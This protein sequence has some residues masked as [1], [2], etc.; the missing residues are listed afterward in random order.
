MHVAVDL[1]LHKD[2]LG[3]PRPPS[4][5]RLAPIIDGT[6]RIGRWLRT[7]RL[8]GSAGPSS[9]RVIVFADIERLEWDERR[10][11]ADL[12]SRLDASPAVSCLLNHPTR[13]LCRYELLRALRNCGWNDFD[14]YRVSEGRLPE[15]YPV[16]LRGEDDHGGANSPLLDS[17][18]AL[19]TEL[20]R[21][22]AEGRLREG[23]L[24]VEFC[25]TADEHGLIRKYGAFRVG[26]RIL[27]RHIF[28]SRNW[29]LKATRDS[30]GVSREEMARIEMDYMEA[31]PH[32]EELM[33]RFGLAGIE[34]GRI[35]YA[36]KD[37]RIQVW[38]INTNPTVFERAHF[39]DP[40]R[41]PMH[42]A[43]ARRFDEALCELGGSVLDEGST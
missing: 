2:A 33:A 22:R 13:V 10:R 28:I 34:Y 37:G 23:T 5:R 26:S 7:R 8:L 39:D 4:R 18:E 36:L 16:F 20:E 14:V 19:T 29:M 27:P 9:P 43:F 24:I 3:P 32:A 12:W 17:R 31:N 38:E 6:R 42:E 15:R 11:A 21:R 30:D 25:D 40:I 1:R 41:R 35:D